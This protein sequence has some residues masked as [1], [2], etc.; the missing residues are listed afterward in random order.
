VSSCVGGPFGEED[1]LRRGDDAARAPASVA[2]VR[3]YGPDG[4]GTKNLAV[5]SACR[6]KSLLF[7]PLNR[8]F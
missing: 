6:E 1:G 2:A 7:V 4:D 5:F 8:T 3:E